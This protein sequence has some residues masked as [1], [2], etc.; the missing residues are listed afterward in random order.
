MYVCNHDYQ[1]LTHNT[2]IL[3]GHGRV[4]IYR[5]T[6]CRGNQDVHAYTQGTLR[7]HAARLTGPKLMKFTSI[8]FSL[9][10]NHAL[11]LSLQHEWVSVF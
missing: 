5:I 9:N 1:L 8:N 3:I 4:L 7:E 2:L 11:V 10:N 6:F